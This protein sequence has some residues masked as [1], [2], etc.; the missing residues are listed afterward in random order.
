M[1]GVCLWVCWY[2]L[3]RVLDLSFVQGF[4]SG[5]RVIRTQGI[6][7]FQ[8][9]RVFNS[10]GYHLIITVGK[11]LKPALLILKAIIKY[12]SFFIINCKLHL[13][14]Y[15]ILC[16]VRFVTF[17]DI[18]LFIFCL[19]N[20][21]TKE[22]ISTIIKKLLNAKYIQL[23]QDLMLVFKSANVNF[24]SYFFWPQH[25]L[26]YLLNGMLYTFKYIS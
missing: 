15:F 20:K 12:N 17:L 2:V 26:N 3:F 18:V 11:N 4:S 8:C 13:N 16:K 22:N 9:L 25:S 5:R 24:G 21:E 19:S 23:E 14:T 6:S 1:D 10:I 7:L